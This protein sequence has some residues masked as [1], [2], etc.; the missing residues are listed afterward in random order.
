MY[1]S[2]NLINSLNNETYIYC[3]H[4]YT[5]NNLKFLQKI[6][7]NNESLKIIK[8]RIHT[9]IKKTGKSIPFK[10]GEE[11]KYNPFLSLESFYYQ[12]YMNDKKLNK[13]QMFTYL[14]DLKNNY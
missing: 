13:I 11:K 6:F 12:K 10:L 8:N 9:Q 5:L 7:F 4:E 3:G 14:R 2:L 1:D